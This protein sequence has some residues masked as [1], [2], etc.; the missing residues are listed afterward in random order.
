MSAWRCGGRRATALL[1][2]G[3]IGG[4]ILGGAHA[5]PFAADG[6]FDRPR[7]VSRGQDRPAATLTL[8]AGEAT[9]VRVDGGVDRGPEPAKVRVGDGGGVPSL[10]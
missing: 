8:D 4:A 7:L 10:R 6:G 2:V 9:L 3:I 1:V 5:Q